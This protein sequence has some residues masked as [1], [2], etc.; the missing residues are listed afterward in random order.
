MTTREH[1][2]MTK[3]ILQGLRE[4]NNLTQH[5]MAVLLGVTENGYWQMENGRRAIS[6]PVKRLILILTHPKHGDILRDYFKSNI[7][8]FLWE[9][10]CRMREEEDEKNTI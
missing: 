7:P 8:N 10:E 3:Q 1:K 6:E 5:D 9:K 4:Q 2:A